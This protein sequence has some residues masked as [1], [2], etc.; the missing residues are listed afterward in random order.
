[1]THLKIPKDRIGAIIGPKGQT[2]K[3]IEEKSSSQLNI[4]SE[5]GSVEVIQGD[6]PVGTL[7]AIETIKAIGRGFNPEK[8]IPMLDEDLLMLEVIDLSKYASTNKEMTR[9][10]GRIIGKGGKT[11]EIA[12]N[13]IGVKISIYGKTVSFIGYPEQIQ[14]M[15]T[16]V[17]MLI[18]GANHGPVYSF[19]E[20]KHKE[21]MQ[22]QLDSY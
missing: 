10:K 2:K 16:A 15:R 3:F 1:M 6:D 4:D 5:N 9:L 8:T 22:A 7:R 17:E 18:E 13:L 20:K 21:L 11:R 12:E 14:I 19:L